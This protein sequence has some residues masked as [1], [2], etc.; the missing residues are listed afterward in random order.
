[1]AAAYG[2]RLTPRV[3]TEDT[4]TITPDPCSIRWGSAAR[5]VHNVGKSERWTSA[6]ICSVV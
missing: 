6:V 3:A 5:Q 2:T 1:L 4:L